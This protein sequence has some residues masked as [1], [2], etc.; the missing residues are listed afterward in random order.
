MPISR[1]LRLRPVT[2]LKH[3]INWT[4]LGVNMS[5]NQSQDIISAVE[6][7]VTPSEVDI[8]S[9][10]NS[11][12]FETNLNGVDNSG[13]VQVFHWL[14]VKN[15]AGLIAP[16]ASAYNADTKKFVIKRGMEMLPQIPIG[17]GGTIQT[18][19]I[20]VVKLPRGM[21]RF[22]DGDKLQIKYIST[23]SSSVNFCG[24]AIYKEFK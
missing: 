18:K 20:F 9:I 8:G 1:A 17:S 11:I 22:D 12:F 24:I 6:S 7:P 16:I 3:E 23:S 5:G 10:V 19:R 4:E 21:R 15:A 2:S 14:I 13:S